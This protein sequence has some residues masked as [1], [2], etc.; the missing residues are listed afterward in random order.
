MEL[1]QAKTCRTLVALRWARSFRTK[2][3]DTIQA[4]PTTLSANEMGPKPK[5]ERIEENIDR[6]ATARPPSPEARLQ[7]AALGFRWR[8]KTASSSYFFRRGMRSISAASSHSAALTVQPVHAAGQCE[9]TSA[10]AASQGFV[11]LSVTCRLDHRILAPQVA[12]RPSC[13]QLL[14]HATCATAGG[15]YN[16]AFPASSGFASGSD[17]DPGADQPEGAGSSFDGGAGCKTTSMPAGAAVGAGPTMLRVTLLCAASLLVS[18]PASNGFCDGCELE[19][20]G[21]VPACTASEGVGSVVVALAG[22]VGGAKELALASVDEAGQPFP[23]LEQHQ[24]FHSEDQAH[25]Q[26]S[27]IA[28]QSYIGATD[29][30]GGIGTTAPCAVC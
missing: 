1:R 30:A 2:T 27:Y 15:T 14:L 20:L 23:W 16:A 26:L 3:A 10:A 5:P 24:A 19:K 7:M 28:P 6:A 12:V 8:G 9:S 4:D 29:N 25:S 17:S 18:E 21:A 11:S 13:V 22:K